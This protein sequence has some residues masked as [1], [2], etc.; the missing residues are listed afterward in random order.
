[1]ERNWPSFV[2]KDLGDT[3]E[4]DAEMHRRWE[5]YDRD[6]RVLIAKGGVHRDGDGWWVDEATGELIGPD[7]EIERP[8]TEGQW[9]AAKPLA[10]VLPD[11]AASIAV[12][13]A[14]RGRPKAETTKTPVTIRLD[15]DLVEHY[16]STGKGW[17]SRMNDDLRKIAG[18]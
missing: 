12:E 5:I 4:D 13:I 2:T 14:R 16:K 18:L 1:M 17:Q 11:L 6:M 3:Q 9:S 8:Q 10:E 15:P 7:P